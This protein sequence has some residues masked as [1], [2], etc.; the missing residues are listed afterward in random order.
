MRWISR[1]SPVAIGFVTLTRVMDI[2]SRKTLSRVTLNTLNASF[3][4][5]VFAEADH[6]YVAPEINN[7][8]QG[9]QVAFD[10]LVTAVAASGAKL[11]MDGD[12]AWPDNILS[13]D[14]GAY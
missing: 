5:E 7:T 1:N 3:C 10:P 11:S 6:F 12:G 14:S 13:S 2:Y 4:V 8:D 9:S